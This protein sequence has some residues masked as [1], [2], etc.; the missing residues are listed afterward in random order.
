ML[1]ILNLSLV[2]YNYSSASSIF[3]WSK[4]YFTK[5]HL[6]MLTFPLSYISINST[7]HS[8]QKPSV[9]S[10]H[11]PYRPLLLHFH[12]IAHHW[13]Y[14]RIKQLHSL[15]RVILKSSFSYLPILSPLFLS[16]LHSNFDFRCIWTNL[17]NKT[18]SLLALFLSFIFYTSS[19][20]SF[21]LFHLKLNIFIF[22]K[23][24][25]KFIS[26]IYTL[27]VSLLF[28]SIK[29]IPFSNPSL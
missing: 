15:F 7:F 21:P 6:I 5:L 12:S 8:S 29:I 28:I 24:I 19:S 18:H 25:Y 3:C 27:Q 2:N 16:F 11:F 1:L 4:N 14:Q 26:L 17:N 9:H 13:S 23:S 20:S 22:S 10:F